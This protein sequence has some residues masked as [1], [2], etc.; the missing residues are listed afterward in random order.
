MKYCLKEEGIALAD[1]AHIVFYDKPFLKFERLLETYIAFAPKGFRSFATAMPIWL[2]EKL[3][4]KSLLRKNLAKA[5]GLKRNQLPPLLFSEHHCRTPH[6]L[7]IQA[8]LIGRPFSV[9]MAW[10]N[11]LQPVHGWVMKIIWSYYGRLISRIPLAC[12]T[13]LSRTTP[14]SV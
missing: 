4:L 9:S 8:R 12:F 3:F 1:V 5:G 10:A 11:G 13:P 14:V 7:F 2:K 6:Q